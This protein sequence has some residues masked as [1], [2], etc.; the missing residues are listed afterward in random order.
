MSITL[1]ICIKIVQFVI[2]ATALIGSQI[3]RNAD[4]ISWF[5]VNYAK[6]NQ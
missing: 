4:K 2:L 3:K 1:T 5:I 6:Y